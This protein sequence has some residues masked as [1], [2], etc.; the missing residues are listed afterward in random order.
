MKAL[1]AF[2]L[3]T[4]AA[5]AQVT[6]TPADKVVDFVGMNVHPEIFQPCPGGTKPGG[7]YC[8]PLFTD[9]L[10]KE[11]IAS[12][13][14][15]VRAGGNA[16]SGDG[17]THQTE[18]F[19]REQALR[20][21]GI[22]LTIVSPQCN[23]GDPLCV[24][25]KLQ[26][27]IEYDFAQSGGWYQAEGLNEPEHYEGCQ[28]ILNTQQLLWN[29][30]RADTNPQINSLPI[31]GPSFD[32]I[33]NCGLKTFAGIADFGNVH[34]YSHE[35]NVEGLQG[36]TPYQHSWQL[37]YLRKIKPLFPGMPV[38]ATEYGW[39]TAWPM[40]DSIIARYEPR[41]ILAMMQIGY[42]GVFRHQIADDRP[43]RVGDINSGYGMIDYL[44]N[45]KP[46]WIAEKNLLAMFNDPTPFTPVPLSYTVTRLNGNTITPYTMLFQKSNGKYLLAIWLGTQDYRVFGTQATCLSQ[47]ATNHWVGTCVNGGIIIK[48]PTETVSIQL[49]TSATSI[50]VH[51]FLDTGAVASHNNG[52]VAGRVTVTA[53]S[54]L[55]VLE[56]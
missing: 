30:I 19:Q 24:P 23:P 31:L 54:N 44:G 37:D 33:P 34:P 20:A 38:Y 36:G 27:H 43:V 1:I 5:A 39:T 7:V 9:I 14:R 4:S 42:A 18:F 16:P 51:E 21:A 13:I 29:E 11:L 28:T 3:L 35:L 26:A 48:S 12:K 25:A 40:P 52:A 49:G 2:F 32:L 8:D 41:G 17:G 56:F 45:L 47:Q 46:Q 50:A 22:K 6:P 15:Y 10:M 55:K 53:T